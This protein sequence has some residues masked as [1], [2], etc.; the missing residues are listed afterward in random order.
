MSPVKSAACFKASSLKWAYRCVITGN[1]WD[2]NF[3]SVY[4]ST[5]LLL[6]SIKA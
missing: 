1:L 3:W 6:A 2:I 4:M 5:L